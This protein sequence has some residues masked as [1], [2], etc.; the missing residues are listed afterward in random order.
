MGMELLTGYD[1]FVASLA[2]DDQQKDFGFTHIIQHS[3]ITDT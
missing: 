1:E 3:E 2:T